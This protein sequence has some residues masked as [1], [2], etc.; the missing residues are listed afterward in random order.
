MRVVCDVRSVLWV[1]H[2]VMWLVYRIR[3]VVCC[4]LCGYVYCVVLCVSCVC[5]V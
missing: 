1:M 4:V 3:C 2:C 5:D